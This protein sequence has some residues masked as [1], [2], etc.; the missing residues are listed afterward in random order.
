MMTMGVVVTG[1]LAATHFQLH[2]EPT[3]A[4]WIIVLVLGVLATGCAFVL[5]S[6]GMKRL[7]AVLGRYADRYGTHRADCAGPLG[8]GGASDLE[9]DWRWDFDLGWRA[10]H[11]VRRAI[12]GPTAGPRLIFTL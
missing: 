6:E 3:T 5:V 10:R 2:S 7:S 1:A 4:T 12:P 9:S 8:L 11:G